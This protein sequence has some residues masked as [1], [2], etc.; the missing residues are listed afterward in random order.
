M[1]IRLRPT[2]IRALIQR[3]LKMIEG[4]ASE[5]NIKISTDFSP[6]IEEAFIDP[7]RINQ[8]LLNLYLNAIEAMEDGGSLSVGLFGDDPRGIKIVISDTGRGIQ[9]KDLDKIFD[10]YF[11]TK[12]SGTGLGLAIVH[13]IIEAHKG[14]VSVESEAG[15]GTTVSVTL[16]ASAEKVH[17]H[18]EV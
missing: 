5:K 8:V 2:S 17:F 1:N 6:E 15:R 3:S 14:E 12:P 4:Q 18:D 10:P 11:T 13:R 9:K 16:P 7:D